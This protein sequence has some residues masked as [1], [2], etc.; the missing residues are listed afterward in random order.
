[1]KRCLLFCAFFVSGLANAFSIDFVKVIC[2]P[3]M[4]Y[5]EISIGHASDNGRIYVLPENRRLQPAVASSLRKKGILVLDDPGA[6]ELGCSLKGMEIT[7][8]N[9]PY[10]VSDH[11]LYPGSKLSLVVNGHTYAKSVDLFTGGDGPFI[12]QLVIDGAAVNGPGNALLLY[13]AKQSERGREFSLVHQFPDTSTVTNETLA[14]FDGAHTLY[15]G[16]EFE[17]R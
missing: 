3:E 14:T 9:E 6:R 17:P 13:T 11:N 10:E 16:H 12:T 15:V 8:K 5:F 7:F 2:I 1:M 4:D